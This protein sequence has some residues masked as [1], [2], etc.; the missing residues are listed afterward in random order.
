MPGHSPI[1]FESF[2][3]ASISNLDGKQKVAREVA[4]VVTDGEVIGAGSGST[5]WLAVH[6]IASRL[7][8]GEL[9]EVT[10]IPT[11]LEIE[12]TIANLASTR[13]GLRLGDLNLDKPD[14]LF[15]GADEVDPD[16]NLIKGRGGALLREK[17][18][19]RSTSDRRVLIDPSKQVRKLGEGFPVPVEVIPRA[20]PV[21]GGPLASLGATEINVRTGSGKDGPVIT[22]SGNLLLDCRFESIQAGLETEIKQIT[23]VIESGLFQGYEPTVTTA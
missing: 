2:D 7:E 6:A 10:L 11:S 9:S 15:D 3:R 1:R 19:F 5:A 18:L 12:L 16:G 21:V 4:S 20:L 13:P 8:I 17:L 22:E 14:W 23:G